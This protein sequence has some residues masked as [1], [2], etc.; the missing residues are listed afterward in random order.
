VQHPID[1]D[2]DPALAA[3]AGLNQAHFWT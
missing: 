1:I 3:L 2:P